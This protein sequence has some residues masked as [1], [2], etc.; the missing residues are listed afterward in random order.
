MKDKE[1]KTV[2]NSKRTPRHGGQAHM[3]NTKMAEFMLETASLLNEQNNMNEYEPTKKTDDDFGK[4][5]ILI[6]IL[7][8]SYSARH[9]RV[10]TTSDRSHL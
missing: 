3:I 6:Y 7:I 4:L 1:G 2:N 10:E 9:G 5:T 8:F